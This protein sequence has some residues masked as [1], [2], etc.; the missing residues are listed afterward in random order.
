M[1]IFVAQINATV[2]D[3]DGNTEK[4][5][6]AI[7][8]AREKKADIVLF[9]ELT[10]CGY[11]PEDLLF[12]PRFIDKMLE[13]LDEIREESKD[14]CVLVGTV[15]KNPEGKEKDIFNSAAI[16][17]DQKIIGF[18]DKTLLP[19]YDIF[20]ERRYFEPGKEQ[21]VFEHKGKRI[22]VLICEDMWEH[23]GGVMFTK[24]RRD[25]VDELVPLKPDLLLNL[26]A[27]PFYFQKRDFREYVFAP[28]TATLKC[29][30]IWCNQ[31]GSNDNLVFDGYSLFMSKDG[32]LMQTAKGFVEDDMIV[33]L[34]APFCPIDYPYDPYHDFYEALV[35]G[36]K[37]YFA[38][39]G[40]EKALIGLSGGIDSALVA[41]V[42][43]DALGADNI[44]C[45]AMPSRFSS[46]SSLEDA[47]DL[48]DSLKV[49]LIDI[50]IDHVFQS[51]LDLLSGVFEGREPDVTEENIQARIRGMILMALSNKYGH[52]V[53]STGNKSEMAM[54]YSTLYGD[55]CGGLGVISD[56]AKTQ[57]YALCRWLNEKRGNIV[58]ENIIVKPPSAELREN[59]MDLDSLPEY[60]IVD[61]I[62]EEYIE[63]H[64][65]IAKIAEKHK[66]DPKL[67][68]SLVH[69]IH[70]AEYKRRQGPPGIRVT[71][72]AFSKGR[73]FPIV[74]KW[75]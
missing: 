31:V 4:I 58:P 68:R 47:R 18:K 67:A 13:K 30:L 38:K 27:S 17:C 62:L 63:N 15:R 57:V 64:L 56:V 75:N 22:G 8:R 72:K 53:L 74:Q 35:L 9:S 5:I 24:Y 37:D 6:K 52:I 21:M 11:P 71:K 45:V 46:L 10:I 70:L 59:Q 48:A 29:P 3:L 65:T 28:C 69:K 14:L 55:M 66:I 43:V 41:C 73:V 19:T 39:Q 60:G 12:F 42:A 49:K 33:D 25:P 2:G 61:T 54:G 1:R 51:F 26:S 44:L 36:V 32:K 7:H 20:D 34:D 50:P 16:I 40:F 23:G